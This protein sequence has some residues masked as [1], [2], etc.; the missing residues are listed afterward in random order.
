MTR[1]MPDHVQ[2]MRSGAQYIGEFHGIG[3]CPSGRLLKV[4]GNIMEEFAC[5]EVRRI[6]SL[7]SREPCLSA[8]LSSPTCLFYLIRQNVINTMS[9]A[10]TDEPLPVVNTQLNAK[11]ATSNDKTKDRGRDPADTSEM[12][13]RETEAECSHAATCTLILGCDVRRTPIIFRENRQVFD[14]RSV[15]TSTLLQL[16]LRFTSSSSPC[17]VAV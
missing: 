2:S 17:A 14:G 16:L 12:I 6:V 1:A 9:S 4:V 8:S 3:E 11:Q 13:N 15:D 7:F 5:I 10:H